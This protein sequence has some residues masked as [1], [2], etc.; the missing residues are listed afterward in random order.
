MQAVDILTEA[1]KQGASD[2]HLVPGAFPYF[3]LDG[4]L[5]PVTAWS[6]FTADQIQQFMH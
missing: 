2:V 6:R 4:Q 5:V 3:R 1:A